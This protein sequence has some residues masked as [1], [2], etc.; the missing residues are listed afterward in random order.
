MA[1]HYRVLHSLLIGAAARYGNDFSSTH[2]V[3][4]VQRFARSVEHNVGFLDELKTLAAA[5]DFRNTDGLAL[6]LAN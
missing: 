1:L 6:L 3:Q 5:P 4:T 2:A